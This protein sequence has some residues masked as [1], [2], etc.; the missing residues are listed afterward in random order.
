MLE[1]QLNIFVAKMAW[2]V[3]KMPVQFGSWLKW[4]FAVGQ[5]SSR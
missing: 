5:N 1:V 4:T 3:A 2:V